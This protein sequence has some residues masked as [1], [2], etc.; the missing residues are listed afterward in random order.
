MNVELV[1]LIFWISPSPKYVMV[2]II[3][4][5]ILINLVNIRAM[6]LIY[7]EGQRETI[8]LPLFL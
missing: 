7:L 1:K 2:I 5:T 3:F 4:L 8:M 6:Q